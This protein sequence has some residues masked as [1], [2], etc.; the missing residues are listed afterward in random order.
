[1][2]KGVRCLLWLAVT[3]LSCEGATKKEPEVIQTTPILDSS[4]IYEVF[5]TRKLH[6]LSFTWNCAGYDLAIAAICEENKETA[7]P[8]RMKMWRKPSL[9]LEDE[10]QT[11]AKNGSLKPHTQFEWD[12]SK[13]VQKLW[14]N[15]EFRQNN[16][17]IKQ[18]ITVPM[19]L[20]DYT[21]A[22]EADPLT[23]MSLIFGGS[24]FQIFIN[25][26]D[27]ASVWLRDQAEDITYSTHFQLE[28]GF[29]NP[30]DTDKDGTMKYFYGDESLWCWANCSQANIYNFSGYYDEVLSPRTDEYQIFEKQFEE[31]LDGMFDS[32]CKFY[33]CSRD[34]ETSPSCLMLNFTAD[35]SSTGET[36]N[37]E[38]L[39]L[40]CVDRTY[41][42]AV[43][44]EK[45]EEHWGRH[46]ISNLALQTDWSQG[47][48]DDVT[49][50]GIVNGVYQCFQR[51]Y[52][53]DL[54]P[55]QLFNFE[56][57]ASAAKCSVFL[58]TGAMVTALLSCLPP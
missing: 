31:S 17:F 51:D 56:G 15:T 41:D 33:N 3:L 52:C 43:E 48:P 20:W 35:N 32:Y 50:K 4:T 19:D 47:V 12:I 37:H 54:R 45:A 21:Y 23:N 40:T 2:S 9:M 55:F 36:V 8:K 26:H 16:D 1:M 49:F 29:F 24:Y 38:L 22:D 18:W 30:P 57:G 53:H 46:N 25:D 58:L 34:F 27:A 44:I 5:P 14:I 6:K 7:N 28:E 10:F 13:D 39:H 42:L 11:K